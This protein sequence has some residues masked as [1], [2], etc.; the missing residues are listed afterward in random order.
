MTF[1]H[2]LLNVIII[3]IVLSI[4]KF[5]KNDS[6]FEYDIISDYLEPLHYD[7]NIKLDLYKNVFY[8]ECNIIIKVYRRIENMTINAGIFSIM[9]INLYDSYNKKM[10]IQK[11]SFINKNN[12]TKMYI[13][14]DFIAP[15]IYILKMIYVRIILEDEHEHF[16]ETFYTDKV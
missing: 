15:G 16:F 5:T 14:F 4:A 8:G 13:N 1:R 7:V 3:V 2:I 6:E 10:D 12:I 11:L 9:N